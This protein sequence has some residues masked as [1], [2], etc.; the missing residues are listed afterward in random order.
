MLV[1]IG[2]CQTVVDSC[3]FPELPVPHGDIISCIQSENMNMMV[4]DYNSD[5]DK[6][7]A[8][9]SASDIICPANETTV[10]GQPASSCLAHFGRIDNN[11]CRRLNKHS[12][13][14]SQVTAVHSN[15]SDL[16]VISSRRD[17]DVA[18]SSF[19][20]E[21]FDC[22]DE[23]VES[24]LKKASTSGIGNLTHDAFEP[25][26]GMN[27]GDLSSEAAK[28]SED[29]DV[30]GKSDMVVE[31][32]NKQ[33]PSLQL[34]PVDSGGGS[35][36][37][38]D[39]VRVCDICGDAGREEFLA[40]CS[41]C[42][43]G[44]EHTY[45]MR[46]KMDKLPEGYWMCEECLL[47]E[48]SEK[49]EPEKTAPELN[50]SHLKRTKQNSRKAGA[51]SD[52]KSLELDVKGSGV[53]KSST[54]GIRYMRSVSKMAA[55][56][57]AKG[58][59]FESNFKS[60]TVSSDCSK[61]LMCRNALFK[62]SDKGKMK[63]ANEVTSCA[64]LSNRA[65]LYEQIPTTADKSS[66][67]QAQY[68]MSRDSLMK[69]QSFNVRDSINEFHLSEEGGAQK[70]DSSG[71]TTTR[72]NKKEGIARLSKS[73]SFNN[74]SSDHIDATNSKDTM[75]S[76][77]LSHVMDLQRLRHDRDHVSMEAKYAAP[78]VH[79]PSLGKLAADSGDIAP[80][81]NKLIT[82]GEAT[83]H[84]RFRLSDRDPN[85][86]QSDVKSSSLSKSSSYLT[87]RGFLNEEQNKIAND[88]RQ[89]DVLSTGGKNNANG[90]NLSDE[91]P[92][93]RN[94]PQFASV[95]AISS[96]LSVV[97]QPECIWKGEFEIQSSGRPPSSCH[98]I[99]AHLSTC[100]SPK[101]LEVVQKL[102]QKIL[103]EEVSYLRTWPAQFPE[104]QA[105][106]DNIALYFFATDIASYER[107]YNSLSQFMIQN[108]LALK[109]A[110]EGVELLVYSSNLLPENSR[111][112]N[113]LLFLWGVFRGRR[114]N[115]SE[116]IPS[117]QERIPLTTY[118]DQDLSQ[119]TPNSSTLLEFPPVTSGGRIAELCET[120][121]SS[122]GMK[123]TNF[124][125]QLSQGGT[126]LQ[127]EQLSRDV[128]HTE[129]FQQKE[130]SFKRRQAID[131]DHCKE[132]VDEERECKRI[133]SIFS[134]DMDSLEGR[135]QLATDALCPRLFGKD[136]RHGEANEEKIISA[137]SGLVD[138]SLGLKSLNVS[139]VTDLELSLG[140]GKY[141][142][143]NVASII[144]DSGSVGELSLGYGADSVIH[145]VTSPCLGMMDTENTQERASNSTR[146]KNHRY[147]GI[148]EPLSLSLFLA[149]PFYN[150]KQVAKPELLPE[151]EGVKTSL[152]L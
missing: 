145:R 47:G 17:F 114:A 63:P 108:D 27:D 59:A 132:R 118:S 8:C 77:D 133:K 71:G 2:T 142:G 11:T 136:L 46:A 82:P 6:Q 122:G 116:H 41:K 75:L 148:D 53:E 127:N 28:F 141:G 58:S 57:V 3:G 64:R 22:C 78:K 65:P 121:V 68:L 137:D 115:S 21:L 85:N 13:D 1:D 124:D 44:A 130:E 60:A 107:N 56:P 49:H 14:H 103:L 93:L 26:T 54:N 55:I 110:F 9:C 35:T 50:V 139:T 69:S 19:K 126:Q 32:L 10:S 48:Q 62:N 117:L 52:K 79:N 113:N 98:G 34:Q 24:S 97:P 38:E 123:S 80:K 87:N 61:N 83:L 94:F 51:F 70:Q 111:R 5:I 30:L 74:A 36:I 144:S 20:G 90:M 89:H 92:V 15:K 95:V 7:M 105:H 12:L 101:V 120:K 73:T 135:F 96:C 18:N 23:Q 119:Q 91:R 131:L 106:E 112:W 81:A 66:K 25:A 152:A 84:Y 150:E 72:N 128:T 31:E 147:G 16:S 138:R 109:G 33:E 146:S 151:R 104:N 40:I 86:D 45:C 129:F 140:F 42:S 134:G 100:A 39:E 88:V 37:L 102:P 4:G 76:Y 149:L 143:A 125:Q 29:M 67:L 43:D 99:Q